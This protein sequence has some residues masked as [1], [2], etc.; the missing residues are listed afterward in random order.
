MLD[1]TQFDTMQKEPAVFG[2]VL[3]FILTTVIFLLN[4][5]IAQL[6]CAYQSTYQDMLGFARLNRGKIVTE[7]M[8]AVSQSRWHRFIASMRLDD[9]VEF[10]EGDLGLSGGM[11]M[12]E[13][14]N[15]NI[16]TVDMIRRFGGSTSMAAQWPEE[17]GGNDEEDRLERIEKT[18]EKSMKMMSSN[19]AASKKKG[20]AM[21]S[22]GMD[23]GGSGTGSQHE[24]AG[25]ADA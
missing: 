24:S 22:S 6:N 4:L 8:P 23:T 18:I 17:A 2:A 20:S 10:G 9:R 1:G 16:T 7:T 3:L 25:S 5:L 12:L 15:A 19:K 14:A 11:Q 21:G 13:P